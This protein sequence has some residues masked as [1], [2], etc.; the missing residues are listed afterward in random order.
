MLSN[1]DSIPLCIAGVLDAGS[2]SAALCADTLLFITGAAS[3]PV[4][5]LL[6][7]LFAPLIRLSCFCTGLPGVLWSVLS[8][9][10][11]RKS[12]ALSAGHSPVTTQTCAPVTH[13]NQLS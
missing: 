7:T 1:Q 13:G 2:A 3:S 6:F 5:Y 4:V 8:D 10:C 12:S 11:D 9:G